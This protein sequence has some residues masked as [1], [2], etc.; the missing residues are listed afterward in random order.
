MDY[1]GFAYFV[2][3]P[4]RLEDLM[5]PHLVEKEQPY[6]IVTEIQLPALDYENF[7]TDMLADRQ[8]I[9]DNAALCSRGE[10]WQCL[11][12][13]QRRCSDGILVMPE[14]GCYVGWAA[15]ANDIEQSLDVADQA[16]DSSATCYSA[17]KVFARIRKNMN[18]RQY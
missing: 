4:R 1:T 9:E 6:R 5:V 10:V 14:G 16:A 7:I 8:F 3:R 15:L 2:E 13:R 17:E 18:E 12:I 11:L